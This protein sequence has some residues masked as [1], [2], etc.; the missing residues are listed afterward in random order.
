[1]TDEAGIG[2]GTLFQFR[3]ATGPDVFTTVGKQ[4]SVTP[5]GI[6]ID[7]IDASHMQSP[8]QFR[9]FIPGLGDGGEV[10][11]EI[12]YEPGGE[13]E[14]MLLAAVQTMKVCRT[15]FP[16]GATVEY[17]AFITEMSPET[18]LDDLRVM[19]VTLKVSGKPVITAAAAPVNSVLPAISGTPQVGVELTAFEGVWQNG[20]TAFT[21]QWKNEG[22]A[23]SGATAKTYTPVAGDVG[24]NITVTVT[25]TNSAG[26][27]SATSAE[28][29]PAIAACG[30]TWRMSRRVRSSSRRRRPPI[31]SPSA[32]MHSVASRRR[33]GG[34]SMRSSRR[35]PTRKVGGSARCAASSMRRW[36]II[37]RSSPCAM[38]VA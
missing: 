37:I 3:T 31:R 9:E 18:P 30:E 32:S 17:S 8:D 25:A 14:A 6:S 22:A 26:S 23:I 19:S 2:Y 11:L 27:A 38:P 29:I 34:C 7:S 16:N 20:P 28:A 36:S 35:W 4:R 24:D 13:G 1:M 21:Y 5:Y 15:V 12:L 10:A 33:Q